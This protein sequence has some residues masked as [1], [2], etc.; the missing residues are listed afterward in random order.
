MASLSHYVSLLGITDIQNL[1]SGDLKK[2]FRSRVLEAHPDK[3]GDANTFDSLLSAFV[4][5]TNAMQRVKGGRASM[6]DIKSPDALRVEREE[7]IET[8]IEAVF[9][10]FERERF[11]TEFE[12]CHVSD[13]TDGYKEWFSGSESGSGSDKSKT[14][15]YQDL[16]NSA[17]IE[18]R[19]DLSEQNFHSV[20]VSESKKGKPEPLDIIL[21]PDAMATFSG[22][23]L[24]VNILNERPSTFTSDFGMSPEFTDIYSAYSQDTI[25]CD[26]IRINDNTSPIMTDNIDIIL[27]KYMQERHGIIKPLSD[28][29]L[30]QLQA[31][32]KEQMRLE[33]ERR[34]KVTEYLHN[35]L[36]YSTMSLQNI[37]VNTKTDIDADRKV[38]T[39]TE[40][41]TDAKV[42][43]TEKVTDTND[44]INDNGVI[45]NI[46]DQVMREPSSYINIIK[47]FPY[48]R[49]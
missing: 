34:D 5:V 41:Q 37:I 20:F 36:P 1:T 12:K 24:G 31:Y 4:Y 3:G 14:L 13:L 26:K 39:D 16:L 9:E 7:N 15:N 29:E 18:A 22:E 48:F 40:A 45:I 25:M 17:R 42:D 38:V 10:E 32:E 47:K 49:L 28:T 27:E 21:H 46:K 35:K 8:F 23:L 44:I 30:E 33:K 19:S 2:A 43:E 6:D 11:N